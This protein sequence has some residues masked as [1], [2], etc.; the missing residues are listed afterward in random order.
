MYPVLFNIAGFTVKTG[1]TIWLLSAISFM[2]LTR[3]RGERLY[4]I[5]SETM[6]RS[7]VISFL[8]AAT[9]AALFG[10]L[11]SPQAAGGPVNLM[12]SLSSSG[13]ILFGAAS[14]FAASQYYRMGFTA[15]ADAASIPAALS[16][17]LWRLG[18]LA[19]GCCRGTVSKAHICLLQYPGEN[20][21]RIPY[22]LIEFSFD[23]ICV[24]LLLKIE[25]IL[26]KSGMEG[27]GII[28]AMSLALYG[29]F[30][31]ASNFLRE[32]GLTP[33]G[34]AAFAVFAV[35]GTAALIRILRP[36]MPQPAR[37]GR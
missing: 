24:F 26:F 31:L 9:G 33:A 6:T 7:S 8:G 23:I 18:C 35:G 12:L 19:E 16:I 25:K 21:A 14:M 27:R 34:T 29:Y 2:I 37:K 15:F 13:A 20:V 22:P 30:R 36:H 10:M 11:E 4:G 5:N 1:E 3:N 28:L 17:A 32:D